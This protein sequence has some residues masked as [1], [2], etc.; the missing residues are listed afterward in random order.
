VLNVPVRMSVPVVVTWSL[1]AGNSWQ[2]LTARVAI[3]SQKVSLKEKAC[4]V[5]SCH[6]MK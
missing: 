5:M 3:P 4:H 6:V 1:R 2:P